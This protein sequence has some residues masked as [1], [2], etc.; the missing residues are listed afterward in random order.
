MRTPHLTSTSCVALT[1][2]TAAFACSDTSATSNANDASSNGSGSSGGSGADAAVDGALQTGPLKVDAGKDQVL[3]G[4]LDKLTLTAT[5]SGEGSASASFEWTQV[6]GPTT[7]LAGAQTA[8]L[9]ASGLA[10]GTFAFRV[11]ARNASG[12]SASDEVTVTV[13]SDA[14]S[15]KG[16]TYYVSPTGNDQN[17][18]TQGA[19]WATLA[20]ATA[21]TKSAGSTIHLAVGTYVEHAV[22]ELAP[23]VCIEGEGVGSVIKAS[24]TA[25]WTP[26]IHATS[27][28]GTD[29]HQHISNVKLDGQNLST[30]WAIEFAGRKNV[31]IH[32]VT[33]VD[34]KDRG[35]II[36]G[37]NDNQY[38]APSIYAT[39][40]SFYNN[41]V[42]NSAAYNTA[43]GVYGRGC[44]NVGGTEGMVI[45]GN[46]ITQD[47]RPVG[48]NGWPIK[49][50]NDGHNRGL[51]IYNNKLTKI[52]FSGAYGG[53]GGWDF[54]VEM[55][56]DEG[57]EFYGNEVRGAGFDTNFQYKGSYPYSVW[58]HDNTFILPSPMASSN[59]AIT[60]EFDTDGAIVENNVIDK[61]S[62]CV[63][64]TPRPGNKI[65]NVVIRKNVCTHVGKTTGNGSNAS[66]IILGP[67]E[68]NF[69][70]DG[71]DILNNTFV[72]D[73]NNRP[74]WGIELG[75]QST[76]TVKNIAIKNNILAHTLAGAIVQGGGVTM[77]GVN[78]SNNDLFDNTQ[79]NDPVFTGPQ[80]TGYTYA[81][82][83]HGDPLFVSDSDYQ[84]KSGSP[85]IDKG[86]DVGLP[87]K[88]SAPD[89]GYAE[90]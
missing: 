58:I 77:S 7:S 47:Q 37:R 24:L 14:T 9:T 10:L 54:A 27:P 6:T 78:I 39:G 71:L 26:I 16:T 84:L 82:N 70:I 42:L 64:F 21:A 59:A 75:G 68:S 50:M 53:D 60:L 44:L 73:P 8:S 33:V 69:N 80:P 40:I 12:A 52:P 76:G 86:V 18:G 34:F 43:N 48:F 66:F 61:M 15:C 51:K 88:G 46:T 36:N 32:D 45:F 20:K 28:E 81:N 5:A 30:F 3:N 67:G 85:A 72:A 62:N 29:G 4:P 90:R 56:W 87:F 63:L 25:D 35:V 74:W 89:I 79:S 11:T 55:F 49:G 23:G 57:T 83:I 13:L 31:S 41:T 17:D 2:F 22:S 38:K 19:P 65:S 1:L